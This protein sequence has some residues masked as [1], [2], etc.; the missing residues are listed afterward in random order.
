MLFRSRLTLYIANCNKLL[1]EMDNLEDARVLTVPESNFRRII[2]G[3]LLKLLD[4]QKQYWKKRCTI[5]W[6]KF[7]D[8]NS[9]FFQSVATDRYRRNFIASLPNSDGI[10][11][12]SHEAKEKIIFDTYKDRLGSSTDPPM[13]FDLPSLIQPLTLPNSAQSGTFQ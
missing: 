5:R 1:L 9:K 10:E 6:T 13:V 11:V 12:N 3:H 8:E 4:F 2:Q 7:G